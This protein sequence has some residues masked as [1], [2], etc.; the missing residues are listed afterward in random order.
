MEATVIPSSLERWME[1]LEE[2]KKYIDEN[3][4][5]PGLNDNKKLNYW[6]QDQ[7]KY[8]K[9]DKCIIKNIKFKKIWEEFI[10]SEKYKK[11]FLSDE[12]KWNNIFIE[13]KNYIDDNNKKPTPNNANENIKFLGR[14]VHTQE[15]NFKQKINII[16]N[17]EV[18]K[19]IWE[20]FINNEKYN[21]YF[22]SYNNVWKNKLNIVKQYIYINKKRPVEISDDSNEKILGGWINTQITNASKRKNSMKNEEIYNLWI[23]FVNDGKNLSILINIKNIYCH[24]KKI[25]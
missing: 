22:L 5:R 3:E 19:K 25:G 10:T 8:Y 4:K 11:Y 2:V 16:K 20:D 18:I 6:I 15:N 7:I 24:T 13:V 9:K 23:D 12:E 21:C 14:W 17:N 1:R